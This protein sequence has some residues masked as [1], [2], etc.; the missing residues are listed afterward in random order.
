VT[1][2]PVKGNQSQAPAVVQEEKPQWT[3]T[4]IPAPKLSPLLTPPQ[5]A[6]GSASQPAAQSPVPIDDP[7]LTPGSPE[8]IGPDVFDPKYYENVPPENNGKTESPDSSQGGGG[9]TPINP[10]ETPEQAKTPP[11]K[12][13][14]YAALGHPEQYAAVRSGL[15]S[16]VVNG[17]SYGESKV[18][19]NL[20]TQ[21][22]ASANK[23]VAKQQFA[24]MLGLQGTQRDIWMKYEIAVID[25]KDGFF[26]TGIGKW[27]E[28][29]YEAIKTRFSYLH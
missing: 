24:D 12:L 16:L 29:D 6:Q 8:T 10:E 9:G 18:I 11:G 19:E 20:V 15:Q 13:D 17:D 22:R 14:P 21:V 26:S 5:P 25:N 7:T 3:I 4:P 28:T 1:Q 27:T 23:D 2:E